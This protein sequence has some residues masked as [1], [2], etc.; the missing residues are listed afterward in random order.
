MTTNLELGEYVFATKYS[1]GDPADGWA[2]GFYD[3]VLPKPGGNRFLVVDGGGTQFRRNGFRRIAKVPGGNPM[4]ERIIKYCRQV[5]YP[6]WP[7]GLNLWDEV[8]VLLGAQ[9][10]KTK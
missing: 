4:G 8:D 9:Y 5:E 1:D 2:L 7:K 10:E 3:G 6:N